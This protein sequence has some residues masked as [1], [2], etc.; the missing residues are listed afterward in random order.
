MWEGRLQFST[1][2]LVGSIVREEGRNYIIGKCSEES[3]CKNIACIQCP[4]NIKKIISE[5][6]MEEAMVRT[7]WFRPKTSPSYEATQSQST[8]VFIVNIRE[9]RKRAKRFW[10]LCGFGELSD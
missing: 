2:V 6:A 9:V 7:K 5:E 10:R 8:S 1:T 4:S 3:T